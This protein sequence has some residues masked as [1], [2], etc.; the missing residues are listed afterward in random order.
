MNEAFLK[1]LERA[2]HYFSGKPPAFSP[3]RME[4]WTAK[5]RYQRRY[6]RRNCASF[7][8]EIGTPPGKFR[9]DRSERVCQ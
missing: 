3:R 4:S 5:M 8:G 6:Q 9:R 2:D 1:Y 7:T